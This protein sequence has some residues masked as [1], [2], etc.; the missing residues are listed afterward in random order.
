MKRKLITLFT[1]LVC[2]FTCWSCTT[3]KNLEST[4]NQELE[5]FRTDF[6]L[7]QEQKLSQI[8]AEHIKEN[9]GYIDSDEIVILVNLK[10]VFKKR[11]QS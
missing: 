7:S 6:K 10:V 4:Q 8:K 1:F 11:A 3:T 2:V 9:K 5:I